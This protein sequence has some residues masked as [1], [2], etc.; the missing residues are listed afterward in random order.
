M[1]KGV[2]GKGGVVGD[3]GVEVVVGAWW[4]VFVVRE[5]GG[6]EVIGWREVSLPSYCINNTYF[7]PPS[8]H[9]FFCGTDVEVVWGELWGGGVMGGRAMAVCEI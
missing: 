4:G 1:V 8:L 6:V 7:T 2:C 9:S 3:V 5:S